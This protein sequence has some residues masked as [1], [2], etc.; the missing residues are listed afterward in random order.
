MN[1]HAR[2]RLLVLL[3][4]LGAAAPCLAQSNIAPA[5]PYSWSENC[6]WMNWQ[7]PGSPAG[8]QGVN[9]HDGYLTGFIWCENIGYINTGDG[10]VSGP[11]YANADGADAGVN[12]DPSGNLTGLA[13]AENVGWINFGGGAMASPAKPAR[14]DKGAARLRGYAWGENI[15][16]INLDDAV[17][18]VGVTGLCGSADFNCDG[19]VGTDADIEAFFACLAGNCPGSPCM[20]SADFNGDGDVGTDADIEA[21]FRVLAGGNC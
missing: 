1:R 14:L 17:A 16:W 3:G 20:S 15:G 21:F 12:I 5:H 10:P 6:G 2:N 11:A 7:V 9:V 19:D 18:F 8:T 13:W 4:A